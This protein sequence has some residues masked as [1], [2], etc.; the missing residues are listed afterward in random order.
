MKMGLCRVVTSDQ[1]KEF[2]NK[3]NSELMRLLNIDHRLTTPYH[4][5]ICWNY[6]NIY[7]LINIILE[8]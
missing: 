5:Q 8:H 7:L 3:L 1:G 4:P 2:N 6:Y